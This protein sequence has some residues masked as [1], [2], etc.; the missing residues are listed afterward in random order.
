MLSRMC[1]MFIKD[2]RKTPVLKACLLR[3]YVPLRFGPSKSV[4]AMNMAHKAAYTNF[5]AILTNKERLP[6]C[7]RTK[8]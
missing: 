4:S 1:A 8:A 5:K 2:R 7:K 6:S 3:F